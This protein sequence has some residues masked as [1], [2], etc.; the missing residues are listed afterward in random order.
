MGLV[1]PVTLEITKNYPGEPSHGDP[2]NLY[3]TWIVFLE[4]F[5]IFGKIKV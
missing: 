2:C 4:C 5:F 3:E 1:I